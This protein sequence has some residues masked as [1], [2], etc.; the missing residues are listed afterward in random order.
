MPR[1][2]KG[3]AAAAP[4]LS[5]GEQIKAARL[6]KGWSMADLGSRIPNRQGNPTSRQRIQQIESWAEEW[7]PSWTWFLE[8]G[9]VWAEL[10]LGVEFL[11]QVC[12]GERLDVCPTCRREL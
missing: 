10:G 11:A 9:E 2:P 7:R 1:K 12:R 5:P 6:A 4:T 3:G 8:H